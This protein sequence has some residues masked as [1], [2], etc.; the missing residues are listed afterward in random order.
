MLKINIVKYL[1]PYYYITLF[2][3]IQRLIW[4]KLELRKTVKDTKRTIRKNN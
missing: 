4:K 2:P 1:L 3:K